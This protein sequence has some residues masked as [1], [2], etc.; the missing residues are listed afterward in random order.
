MNKPMTTTYS[1][2]RMFRNCRK[3]CEYR[4]LRNLVPMEKDHNMAF[5][6]VIHDCLEI[7]HGKRELGKVI[8]HIEHTY[9]NRAQD[10]KQLADWHLA[11]AM[12]TQ[13]SKRFST[14]E[15]DVVSLEKKFEGSII[16]PETNAASRSFLLAGKVDG[17]VMQDGQYFLLEHKTAAQIDAGYLERLWMDFQIILYAWYLEQTLGIKVTGIIYNVL[18]KAKLR[19]SKG[20]TEAEFETRRAELIAKSKTGKSSAKRKMPET[21]EAFQQR[22]RAK[23]DDPGMFHREVLY[24]SRDQF[25]ELRTELWEL[26][27]AMLDARRR[28]TFYRNTA[29]CFQYGRACPYFPLCRSGENPNVIENCFEKV[30]PH[31]ELRTDA[32]NETQKPEAENPIF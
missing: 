27:K 15:F 6:S 13:Y 12:M 20:E 18:V 14:E 2:W 22:L 23:Y 11:T 32:K 24:I 26:S 9:A 7:W 16:N 31:E 8:E 10:D 21:D 19:Q 3:A 25:D 29:F 1:M 4:Y 17:L 30:L 5:G 28:N